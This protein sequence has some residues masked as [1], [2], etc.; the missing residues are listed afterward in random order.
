M[1]RLLLEIDESVCLCN[2][3]YYTSYEGQNEF[4]GRYLRIFEK[5]RVVCRCQKIEKLQEKHQPISDSRIE[6][7][8]IPMFRGIVGFLKMQ[9]SIK[10]IV[11][12][13]TNG[14]DCGVLRLPSALAYQTYKELRYNNVSYAVEIVYD[15]K[16]GYQ[17]AESLLE[18]VAWMYQHHIMQK[19]AH[20]AVGVACVTEKYLQKHYYSKENGNFV[21]NYST[22]ALPRSFYSSPRKYPQNGRFIISH[23]ANQIIFK[24]RKGHN[25]VIDAVSIL[26]DRGYQVEVSFAGKD[27]DNGV[28]QLE[29]YAHEKGAADRVHFVGFLS[30]DELAKYLEQSDLYVMPTRAEGLPRVIIEAMAKGLPCLTTDVSG[31]SELVEKDM[32]F[33]YD[34]PIEL[35]D[36]IERLISSPS[37]YE[38]VSKSNFE[39]S[40]KYEASILEKR[41]DAFYHNLKLYGDDKG[42]Q[43]RS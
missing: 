15:A 13:V 39:R 26:K 12:N 41:R 36:K 22:L 25:E 31:N 20:H 33:D 19:M 38:E 14:C 3:T 16:D 24:G 29:R 1:A 32:M 10:K 2:N 4:F 7:V 40:L 8:P 35:A 43:E 21:S 6:L 42:V 9:G 23:I 27:Y 11:R 34:N 5:L 28:P 37:I 30:R 18:R 17:S